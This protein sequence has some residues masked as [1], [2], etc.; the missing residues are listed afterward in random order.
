MTVALKITLAVLILLI[1][2]LVLVGTGAIRWTIFTFGPS[3]VENFSQKYIQEYSFKPRVPH[4]DKVVVIV[5]PKEDKS[6][7][8]PT[9]LSV[10]DQT[11]KVDMIAMTVPY[12]DQG[13]ITKEMRQIAAVYPR[14]PTDKNGVSTMYEQEK[15]A[16]TILVHLMDGE[17][18]PKNFI[19]QTTS[20]FVNR[21][22]KPLVYKGGKAMITTPRHAPTYWV[23]SCSSNTTGESSHYHHHQHHRHHHKK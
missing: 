3:V 4:K 14:L 21:P 7:L 23:D 19:Y 1:I 17:I 22:H 13:K 18:Y 2:Y 20:E 11:H 16:D 10:L 5:N 9:L 8:L 15:E 12:E 6:S